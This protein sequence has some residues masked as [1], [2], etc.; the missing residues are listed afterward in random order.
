MKK[1]IL[2]FNALLACYAASSQTLTNGIVVQPPDVQ[3]QFAHPLGLT[4]STTT[5]F[6]N[7]Q[8]VSYW[9]LQRK[10]YLSTAPGGND[11]NDEVGLWIKGFYQNTGTALP[12]MLGGYG[13]NSED[14]HMIIERNGNIGVGTLVPGS[15]YNQN[16]VSYPRTYSQQD[17]VV[18]IASAEQPVLELGRPV[19]ALGAGERVG[20]IF[21]SNLTGQSDAHRQVAGIWAEK[22]DLPS[23]PNLIGGKLVFATK[24]NGGAEHNKIIMDEYGGLCIGTSQSSGYKLAVNGD[25]KTRRIKVTVSEWPDFVFQPDYKLKSLEEVAGFIAKHKHLPEIPAAS[26]VQEHGLDVGGNQAMLLR[27]IEELTLYMIDMNKKMAA[28]EKVMKSQQQKLAKQEKEIG[29]LK[30]QLSE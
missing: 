27:K 24:T 9:G 18:S 20:A 30:K 21:F 2:F 14:A 29:A 23:H 25:I 10:R 5:S 7:N 6:Q 3:A 26:E 28:Q 22:A 16:Q 4:M 15:F 11:L 19:S 8:A 13:Y 12:V 1:F 17:K